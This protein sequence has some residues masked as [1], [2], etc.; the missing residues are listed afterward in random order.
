VGANVAPLLTGHFGLARKI[1]E[2]LRGRAM[3]GGEEGIQ[4]KGIGFWGTLV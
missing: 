1:G 4:V 2:I 3:E